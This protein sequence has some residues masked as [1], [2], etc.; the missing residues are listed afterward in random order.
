MSKREICKNNVERVMAE[1][2]PKSKMSQKYITGKRRVMIRQEWTHVHTG[3][4]FSSFREWEGLKTD[5]EVQK[6]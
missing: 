4:F 5:T 1:T 6:V 3:Q 2:L